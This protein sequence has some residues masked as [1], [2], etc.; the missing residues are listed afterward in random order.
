MKHTLLLLS[1]GLLL[2]TQITCAMHDSFTQAESRLIDVCLADLMAEHGNTSYV[3][4]SPTEVKLM[5]LLSNFR[6]Q[7]LRIHFLQEQLVQGQI[8]NQVFAEQYDKMAIEHNALKVAIVNIARQE[9]Q[10]MACLQLA[11]QSLGN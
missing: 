4:T 11:A 1:M 6:Q 3:P 9:N 5:E 2:A 8:P 7:E 10:R